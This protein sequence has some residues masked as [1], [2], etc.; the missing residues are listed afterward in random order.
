M[1]I[2]Y[3]INEHAPGVETY[4]FE[5]SENAS[6]K[7]R[8]NLY[9]ESIS[10]VFPLANKLKLNIKSENNFPHSAGIASSAS[11]FAALADCLVQIETQL[12]FKVDNK[13]QRTSYLAR[14]GSGSA[15]RSI[16]HG[17]FNLWGET[18]IGIGDNEFGTDIL[19]NE[20]QKRELKWPLL[21]S[22]L[23]VSSEQKQV[24]SSQGHALMHTHLYKDVRIA[25]A[26]E[27]L[28]VLYQ[29]ILNGDLETFGEVV[30]NEALTL[31]ALMMTSY[32]AFCLLK[33]NSLAIIEKVRAFRNKTDLNLYFTIDAGPNIHLIYPEIQ[34]EAIQS[35]IKDEL[36]HLC[37][38]VIWGQS[39]E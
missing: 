14:L 5:G 35:F 8:I 12:G 39:N 9:L 33:P 24:S 3:E 1:E 34:S 18:Q 11:A 2:S 20:K 37:E 23:I 10:D 26:N 6:F 32:P 31:H 17:E 4:F 30:E 7:K 22:I 25:Q 16:S 15:G 28:R 29:A 19:L 13:T 38:D 36:S 27:N 21:D